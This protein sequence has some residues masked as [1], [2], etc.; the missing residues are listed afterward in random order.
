MEPVMR[1]HGLELRLV[2]QTPD[3]LVG[4]Y[5]VDQGGFGE[6]FIF[7][8]LSKRPSGET[9]SVTAN[10]AKVV[11]YHCLRGRCIFQGELPGKLAERMGI[12]SLTRHCLVQGDSL[13]IGKAYRPFD[14]MLHVCPGSRV[15][16]RRYRY[17][18][19]KL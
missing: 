19:A 17:T 8:V 12:A 3:L 10:R 1:H 11:E 16:L 7:E 18:R 15:V 14:H 6:I 13:P 2:Y 5:H 4:V 9:F